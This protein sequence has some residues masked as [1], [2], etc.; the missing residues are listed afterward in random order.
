MSG[1]FLIIGAQKAGTSALFKYLL[2]HP[3]VIGAQG[4]EVHFFSSQA[5]YEM[6]FSFYENQFPEASNKAL[7]LDASPSYLASPYAPKRIFEF[8]PN[9]KMIVLLRDPVDRAYS[10]WQM[11]RPRYK[12]DRNWFVSGWLDYIGRS[13]SDFVRRNDNEIDDFDLYVS[14]EIKLMDSM[15]P[16]MIEAPIIKQ[17]LY[18]E[19][20]ERYF[21]YFSRDQFMIIENGELRSNLAPILRRIESFL[22]LSAICWEKK[23]L[24]P[25]FEG[26]YTEVVSEAAKKK[27]ANFYTISNQRLFTMLN[28]N[29]PWAT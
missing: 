5:R 4:K 25:V 29:Y 20:L 18:A 11:Y 19:Y 9:M 7:R 16:S 6:G 3:E 17:G 12:E 28:C 26:C 21:Q 24:S 8:D 15:S 2:Q 27:L 22:G 23:D 14:A 1:I 13:P 10:A